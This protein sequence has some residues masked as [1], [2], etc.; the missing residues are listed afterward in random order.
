[1]RR[2]QSERH[3]V[4]RR[5]HPRRARDDHGHVRGDQNGRAGDHPATRAG[6]VPMGDARRRVQ[7]DD[8]AILAEFAL[9]LPLLALLAFGMI[10]YGA[11]WNEGNTLERVTS[12]AGRI[13]ATQ[14]KAPFTDYEVLQAVNTSFGESERVEIDRI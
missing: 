5:L 2:T 10:E 6:V 13:A 4:P 11:A 12:Y 9:A 3:L 8:G 1:Q 14:G 7:G